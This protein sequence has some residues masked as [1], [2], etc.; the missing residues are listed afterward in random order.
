MMRETKRIPYSS[1]DTRAEYFLWLFTSYLTKKG[2]SY[3]TVIHVNVILTAERF[4]KFYV[5]IKQ[6]LKSV[7][8]EKHRNQGTHW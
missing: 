3:D 7:P 5:R 2:A 6:R 4:S 1:P 8:T